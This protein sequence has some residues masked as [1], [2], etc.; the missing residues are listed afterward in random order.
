MSKH[1]LTASNRFK[2][3]VPKTTGDCAPITK[4]HVSI[5]AIPTQWILPPVKY[6]RAV[7]QLLQTVRREEVH[8][9]LC[10]GEDEGMVLT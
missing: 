5:L 10:M 4:H 3:H 1:N 7:L 2:L 6:V 9:N 8:P